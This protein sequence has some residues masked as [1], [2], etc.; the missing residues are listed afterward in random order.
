MYD[1]IMFVYFNDRWYAL[2][3]KFTAHALWRSI[4]IRGVATIMCGSVRHVMLWH[5]ANWWLRIKYGYDVDLIMNLVA[6]SCPKFRVIA[7]T[8]NPGPR[9]FGPL[10]KSIQIPLVINSLLES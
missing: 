1:R 7:L 4:S 5:E 10:T 3:G 8:D 2:R 6:G 9:I